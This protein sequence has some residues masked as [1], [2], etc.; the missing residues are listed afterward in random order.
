MPIYQ[1]DPD[2]TAA[3]REKMGRS[4]LHKLRLLAET[5]QK[6]F[7]KYD[8]GAP[9]AVVLV[10]LCARDDMEP[11]QIADRVLIPRQTVTSILDKLEAAGLVERT[12]HPSDRRRKIIR[13]TQEGFDLGC[14]IW[15]DLDTYETRVMEAF[16]PREIELFRRL[17]MKLAGRIAE[18]DE[19]E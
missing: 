15:K 13:L 14:V 4:Q 11:A 18:L 19:K 17:N 6:R 10:A 1:A 7:A 16:T 5:I 2:K 9:Q 12:D 8:I 3:M